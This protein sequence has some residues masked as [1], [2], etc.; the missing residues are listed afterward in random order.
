MINQTDSAT[1]DDDDDV[2]MSVTIAVGLSHQL[3]E[4][5]GLSVTQM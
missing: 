1:D 3:L 4:L 2:C 5:Q